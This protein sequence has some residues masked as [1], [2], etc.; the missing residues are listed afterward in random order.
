MSVSLSADRVTHKY[1]GL[2]ALDCV[3][4]NIGKDTSVAIV[5]ES[6]SG[7]TTLLR[8][9]NR[10]VEP[11]EGKIAVGETDVSKSDP[12]LL[13]R[14]LGYVQQHGGLIPH[15]NV[16]ANVGTV[17]R[18]MGKPDQDAVAG[19][20]ALVGLDPKKF[21]SRFPNELSGGQR[22]RVALA[23]AL[24]AK[25]QALLLDEP[26]G[27]LDAISRTEV[28]DTFITAHRELALTMLL[29][30]HDLGEA[31]RLAKDIVVMRRGKIEQRGS[32]GDLAQKP[33]TEYVKRLT[34]AAVAQLD[35]LH[36]ARS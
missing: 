23:R 19:S 12:I 24:A 1:A 33:A 34:D 2:T 7:K 28:Q 32:I 5:G 13:R 29:V 26:F 6:G 22:Q 10:M 3:S 18:A 14:Q 21:S 17:L 27:A 30:T 25:P 35:S 16:A 11:L 8:C 31:A 9:F 20:L 15:W 4:L 36:D